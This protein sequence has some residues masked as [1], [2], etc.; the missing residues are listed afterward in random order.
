MGRAFRETAAALV[1]HQ[2]GFFQW[3]FRL[4]AT[5]TRREPQWQDLTQWVLVIGCRPYEQFKE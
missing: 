2:P 3:V 5:L 4:T 1:Q